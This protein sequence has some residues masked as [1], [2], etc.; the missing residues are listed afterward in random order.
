[1][2]Q[3]GYAKLPTAPLGGA[4]PSGAVSR[5]ATEQEPLEQGNPEAADTLP[6]GVPLVLVTTA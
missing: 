4:E 2:T 3:L 5:Y 6:E 1:M